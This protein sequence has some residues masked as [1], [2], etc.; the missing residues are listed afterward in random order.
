M[1]ADQPDE[2]GAGGVLVLKDRKTVLF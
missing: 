2:R 1:I